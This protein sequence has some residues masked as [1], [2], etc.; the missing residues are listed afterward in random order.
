MTELNETLETKDSEKEDSIPE[1]SNLSGT[2]ADAE[3][4]PYFAKTFNSCV[5]GLSSC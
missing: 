1:N 4:N 5:S 2:D 3:E